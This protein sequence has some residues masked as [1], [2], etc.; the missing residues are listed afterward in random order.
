M[1]ITFLEKDQIWQ[2]EQTNYWFDVDGEK[3]AIAD[4]CGEKKLLDFEGFPLES[5]DDHVRLFEIL[6]DLSY[7]HVD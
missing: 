5:N 3:Y 4:Q 6:L 1:N 2:N 7:Q